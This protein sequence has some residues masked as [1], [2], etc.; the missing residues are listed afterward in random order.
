MKATSVLLIATLCLLLALFVQSLKLQ[1]PSAM[2]KLT[3]AQMDEGYFLMNKLAAH[4]KGVDANCKFQ[5]TTKN[6]TCAVHVDE[7]IKLEIGRAHV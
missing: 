5:E 6:E 4:L 2:Q 1:Q 3:P 7:H